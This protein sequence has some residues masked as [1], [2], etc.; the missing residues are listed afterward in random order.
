MS[1][2]PGVYLP[3]L[4]TRVGGTASNSSRSFRE[5]AI[6]TRDPGVTSRAPA[7]LRAARGL[8]AAPCWSGRCCSLPRPAPHLRPAAPLRE[9]LG[10]VGDQP[11]RRRFKRGRRPL[12][13]GADGATVTYENVWHTDVTF[14]RATGA[15]RRHSTARGPAVR[16]GAP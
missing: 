5:R 8:N 3:R 9:P 16:R 15:Q 2:D 14:T 13:Q 6:G 12:R 7:R 1:E 10:R 4:P 11:T